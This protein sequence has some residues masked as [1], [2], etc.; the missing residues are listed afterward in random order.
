MSASANQVLRKPGQAT[1]EVGLGHGVRVGGAG[2]VVLA[3]PCALEGHDQ[4]DRSA[5]AVHHAGAHVLR[6]G[7]FKPRT[8]PYSFQ[9]LG[10]PG[11]KLLKDAGQRLRMPVVSEVMDASQL[12][13]M[14][15]YV[16]VLQ[17]G[18]RN[19]QNFSLLRAV[20]KA[21][22]PVVLK[23]GF[24]CTL[25][26]WLLAAEYMLD[27]GL[28]DVVLCERG[29]RSFDNTLRNTLDLAGV[30]WMKER[31]HLP[32]IVDPSHS[33]GQRSLVTPMALAAAAAGADGL[34][35]EVHPTPEAALCDGPQALTPPMFEALM[36]ALAPVLAAVGRPLF[37]GEARRAAGGA[38]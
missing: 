30:A 36:Q 2:F 13:V 34:M 33:T 14:L 35:V 6:G 12:S 32:V 24:G 11:L 9:G 25:E 5:L 10:E 8:S 21:G 27:G 19:M 29:I 37:G 16:D 31:T 22:R 7:A 1:T 28:P 4:V 26:E 20:A 38:R 23:R 18:A 17:I 15:D 3:G